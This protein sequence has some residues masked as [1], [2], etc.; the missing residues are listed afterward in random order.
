ML[1]FP[2]GVLICWTLKMYVWEIVNTLSELWGW[3]ALERVRGQLLACEHV[4]YK[5]TF[6]FTYCIVMQA[7]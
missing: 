5:L 6:I 2:P 1:N 4:L 7:T 3:L